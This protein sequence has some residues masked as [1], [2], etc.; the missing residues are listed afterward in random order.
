M[1]K[2]RKSKAGPVRGGWGEGKG[3][4]RGK[5]A[6]KEEGGQERALR[7]VT[8]RLSFSVCVPFNLTRQSL[9]VVL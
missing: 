6:Y 8:K 7:N 5:K 1:R 4:G 9:C 2:K 3:A